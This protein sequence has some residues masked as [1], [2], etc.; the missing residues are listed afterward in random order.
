MKC[1]EI[2]KKI[3]QLVGTVTLIFNT[4][5]QKY[6][7]NSTLMYAAV[8]IHC[9]RAGNVTGRDDKI[10]SYDNGRESETRQ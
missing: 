5:T 4:V 9:F 2:L 10:Q 6:N 8:P 3:I 1:V 7:L